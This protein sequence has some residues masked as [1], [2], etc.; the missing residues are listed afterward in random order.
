MYE[1]Y[2]GL[3]EK[4]FAIAPDPRYLYMSE[5]HREA[6]AHLLY[7]INS[8]GCMV[9][10]TGGVGTGKTTVCR[11]FFGQIPENTDVAVILNPQ[12]TIFDL[13]KTICEEFGI[14]IPE[15]DASIK[16]YT[17]R[18][19]KYLLDSHAKGR[20]SVVIIDE[21]QNLGPEVL[22]QL[23]LLTNLETNTHKLLKIVLIGQPE[24]R[25]IL[26]LPSLS[27]INQ[28][29]T[30]R[31]HL[32]PLQ[33]NQL[34]AYIEHRVSVAGQG[35]RQ[36]IFTNAAISY[37]GK[38]AQGIPRVINVICDR[39]LLGAYAGNS[40]IVTYKIAKQAVSEVVTQKQ[41]QGRPRRL[42]LALG[43][44]IALLLFAIPATMYF[45]QNSLPVAAENF[46]QSVTETIAG[47]QPAQNQSPSVVN[48]EKH[49]N[50]DQTDLQEESKQ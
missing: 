27:Q 40:D 41:P 39:A 46:I 31:Y 48:G 49:I 22:E 1:N 28:R 3:S 43:I 9:L 20:I 18:L 14:E 16:T 19:N 24:L 13:L 4:P 2:F 35:Q 47:N 12:L 38:K 11:C 26:L 30:T 10:L 7:G 15:G 23:R 29:I 5:M 45:Q 25:D 37:I 44:V 32:K 33:Q 42:R 50:G 8:D 36:P 17:D 34:K 21:A 6:L